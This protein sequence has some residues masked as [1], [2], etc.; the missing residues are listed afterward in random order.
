M[1]PEALR[2]S[3]YDLLRAIRDNK[4]AYRDKLESNYHSSDPRRM[5]CG[6]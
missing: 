1:D 4:R 6:L 5:W 3:R 2:R